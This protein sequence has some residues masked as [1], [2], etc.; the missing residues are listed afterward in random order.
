VPEF[1]IDRFRNR[2]DT[3]GLVWRLCDPS[4]PYS[5]NWALMREGELR[6]ALQLWI[7]RCLRRFSP[8]EAQHQFQDVK[9]VLNLD[10][11]T[12][13][14]LEDL[15]LGWWRKVRAALENMSTDR[16]YLIYRARVWFEWMADRGWV[17][18]DA[19][20][21]IAGWKIP[22]SP[23][24]QAVSRRDKDTGPLDDIQF[25]VLWQAV[26]KP[27]P[28]TNGQVATMI[29]L[30]LGPNAKNLALLEERDLKVY[31]GAIHRVDGPSRS[32]PD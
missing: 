31:V 16:R 22:S 18:E 8:A 14:K 6:W 2:V 25:N 3:T 23:K 12:P 11:P 19:A 27:Q 20:F 29:C 17:D 24:G 7:C 21:E 13:A 28:A 9:A 26:L 1:V 15:D 5:M 4:R 30:D 10:L 32:R